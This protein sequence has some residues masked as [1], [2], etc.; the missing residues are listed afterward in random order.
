MRDFLRFWRFYRYPGQI[1][2]AELRKIVAELPLENRTIIDAPC[3]DGGVAYWLIQA[4]IGKQY[5]LYDLSERSIAVAR[6]MQQWEK[7]KPIKLRIEA[8]DILDVP[9]PEASDVWLLINSLYLLPNTDQLL[10]QMHNRA[11][12][13]IGIFPCTESANYQRYVSREP[14]RNIN[15]MSRDE[16]IAYFAKHGYQLKHQKEF[17]YAPLNYFNSKYA[18]LAATYFLNPIERFFPRREACYWMGVFDRNQ[19]VAA[20]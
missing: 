6:R 2:G 20:N 16:T 9:A 10:R 5:E 3:G 13:I 19:A 1:W 17:C 8:C 7:A 18:R 11:Q 12:T 4:G 14:G 15:A